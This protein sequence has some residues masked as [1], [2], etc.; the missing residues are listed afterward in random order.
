[1]AWALVISFII[2]AICGVRVPVLIFTLIVILVIAVFVATGLGLGY[3]IF[4][5]FYWSV[6]LAAVI[7][8]GYAAAHGVLYLFYVN[9]R[10]R[11]EKRAA[12]A[13]KSKYSSD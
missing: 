3:P 9:G 2:G 13:M 4:Q 1:M 7:E 6:L 5:V 12:I 8:A 10:S 11:R